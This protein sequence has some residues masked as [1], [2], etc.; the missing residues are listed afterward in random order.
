MSDAFNVAARIPMDR[1][2]FERWLSAPAP[3]PS[4][5][6]D[7]SGM[8]R[9]W[10]WEDSSVPASPNQGEAA[11]V[12]GALAERVG[13]HETTLTLVTHADD[14]LQL[15]DMVMI[16]P[17]HA[18][19]QHT[20]AMLALAGRELAGDAKGWFVYWADISGRLPNK[21]GVLSLAEVGGGGTRFVGPSDLKRGALKKTL[22]FLAPVGAA[23]G[24]MV[25]EALGDGSYPKAEVLRSAKYVDP[26]VLRT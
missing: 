20:M 15:F 18:R 5:L 3:V 14:C 8:Y 6:L 2:A 10:Y 19:A 1:A 26:A 21:N 7:F 23:F 9:G 11:T 25:G 22:A 4:E 12:R 24:E 16:G 13:N 17:D